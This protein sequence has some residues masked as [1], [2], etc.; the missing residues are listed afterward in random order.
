MK[1]KRSKKEVKFIDKSIHSECWRC[2]GTGIDP[3]KSIKKGTKHAPCMA[4]EGTGKW[5]EP[6]YILV[7][8]NKKGQRIAFQCDGLS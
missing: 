2:R 8:R 3:I 4:C 1:S 7:A 5:K 6:N